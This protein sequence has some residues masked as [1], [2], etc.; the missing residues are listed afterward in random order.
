MFLKRIIKGNKL[1]YSIYSNFKYI[2]KEK[3]MF[4]WIKTL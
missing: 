1:I 3:N 2:Y 4:R